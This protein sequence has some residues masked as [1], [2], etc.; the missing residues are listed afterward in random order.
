MSVRRICEDVIKAE[1]I[2]VT[3][4]LLSRLTLLTSPNLSVSFISDHLNNTFVILLF[5]SVL[6]WLSLFPLPVAF[7][8]SVSPCKSLS[9]CYSC[10]MFVTGGAIA[11]TGWR[12]LSERGSARGSAWL[13]WKLQMKILLSAFFFKNSSAIMLD[14]LLGI[15]RRW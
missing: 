14:D 15:R 13:N 5:I 7:F 12:R 9:G 8:L 10:L 4:T 2:S 6:L 1:E 3:E 11:L